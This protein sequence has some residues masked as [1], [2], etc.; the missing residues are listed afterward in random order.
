[1]LRKCQEKNVR[2]VEKWSTIFSRNASRIDSRIEI[3]P[4]SEEKLSLGCRI[5]KP[6]ATSKISSACP[7]R[8]SSSACRDTVRNRSRWPSAAPHMRAKGLQH[9]LPPAP[10]HR[11]AEPTRQHKRRLRTIDGVEKICPSLAGT[12]GFYKGWSK[13]RAESPAVR[14]STSP[15]AESHRSNSDSAD[16]SRSDQSVQALVCVRPALEGPRSRATA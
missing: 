11:S 3:S 7:H 1:M 16:G 5:R 6:C 14:S 2:R 13:Y 4:S 10:A 8:A 15:H 12:S 9:R